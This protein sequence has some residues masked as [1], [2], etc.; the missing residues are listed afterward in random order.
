M[1]DFKTFEH[2]RSTK[3]I[4]AIVPFLYMISHCFQIRIRLVH[5]FVALR[6]HEIQAFVAGTVAV[7]AFI[8]YGNQPIESSSISSM[9]PL[10]EKSSKKSNFGLFIWDKFS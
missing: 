8:L 6:F 1:F 4:I 7:A 2:P 9:S 5:H 3:P 10:L